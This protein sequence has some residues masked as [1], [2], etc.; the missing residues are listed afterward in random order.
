MFKPEAVVAVC[1]S[2][3]HC[4]DLEFIKVNKV[5]KVIKVIKALNLTCTSLAL[6]YI[7][8]QF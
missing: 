8:D 7:S 2:T 3:D 4:I 5:I 1:L 6:Q